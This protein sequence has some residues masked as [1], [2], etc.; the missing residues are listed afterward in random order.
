MTIPVVSEKYL[1]AQKFERHGQFRE[2]LQQIVVAENV[3]EQNIGS[4]TSQ[5]AAWT[6]IRLDEKR[7]LSAVFGVRGSD[8]RVAAWHRH[9]FFESD[10]QPPPCIYYTWARHGDIIY[11]HGGQYLPS[12]QQWPSQDSL[13][14]FQMKS[15]TWREVP[16]SGDTAGPRSGHVSVVH[17]NCM[18][19]FGGKSVDGMADNKLYRL[20]LVS[21]QWEVVK[22]KGLR[23]IARDSAAGVLYKDKFYIFGGT[24]KPFDYLSDLWSYSFE[25]KRWKHISGRGGTPRKDHEMW[26]AF[27]KPRTNFTSWAERI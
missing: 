2:A 12:D 27:F 14:A 11:R 15:K 22:V 19:V 1:A 18:Y 17:N 6:Q 7:L 8:G 24:S 16:T 25:S 13:W 26:A 9:L 3:L 20:D 5:N 4:N 21:F 10:M 23:P